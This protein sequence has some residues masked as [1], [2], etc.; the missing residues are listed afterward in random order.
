MRGERPAPSVRQGVPVRCRGRSAGGP[1]QMKPF[2]VHHPPVTPV[3]KSA[4]TSAAPSTSI[5]SRD[6][7][8]NEARTRF[9]FG[10]SIWLV[11]S[12]SL[13]SGCAS[14]LARASSGAIGCPY[15]A[16][17]V[18]DVSVGWSQISWTASCRDMVF[19]CSGEVHPTCSA[20][21]A[22]EPASTSTVPSSARPDDAQGSEQ[23]RSEPTGGSKGESMR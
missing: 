20:S 22:F 19:H 5:R 1:A 3:S 9:G 15:E 13:P 16:V 8:V 21:L 14:D 10:V 2:G 23:G 18:S 12:C 11:A 4:P 17:Q 7:R 6:V